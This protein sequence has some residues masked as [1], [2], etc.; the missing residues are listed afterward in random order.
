M[1]TCYDVFDILSNQDDTKTDRN[2]NSISG[3][4]NHSQYRH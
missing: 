2:S 3:V 1:N 4:L